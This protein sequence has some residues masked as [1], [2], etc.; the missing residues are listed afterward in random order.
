MLPSEDLLLFDNIKSDNLF[1][2]F[3]GNTKVDVMIHFFFSKTL[4]TI[5]FKS[6]KEKNMCAIIVALCQTK[7][8]Y[9]I[10][11]SFHKSVH[12]KNILTSLSQASISLNIISGSNLKSRKSKRKF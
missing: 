4:I 8:T 2:A 5:F 7:P 9:C 11:Y 1:E 12:N 6:L 10:V 3:F